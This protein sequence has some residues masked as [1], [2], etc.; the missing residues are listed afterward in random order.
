MSNDSFISKIHNKYIKRLLIDYKKRNVD[1]FNILKKLGS[2]DIKIKTDDCV[3][4]YDSNDDIYLKKLQAHTLVFL[5][6]EECFENDISI[7]DQESISEKIRKDL[8]QII[9]ESDEYITKIKFELKDENL[10]KKFSKVETDNFFTED[11]ES[12]EG[13]DVNDYLKTKI[14]SVEIPDFW[15]KD[16]LRVFISH[17]VKNYNVAKKLKDEFIKSSLSCFVAHKDIKPTTQWQKE[18]KKALNSMELMVALITEDFNE[19]YW[20]H[21]EVGFALGRDIPIIPIKLDQSDPKG[22]ISEIQAINLTETDI[23]PHYQ[24]F[25]N[26]LNLIQEKF[27]K[28]PFIKKKL[29]SAFLSAK[30]GSFA[31]AKEKFMEIISLDFND[32]EIEEIV[33]TIKGP[34]SKR[35]NQLTILLAPFPPAATITPEHLKQLPEEEKDKYKYYS[36]LLE[37]KVLSQHTQK[38]YF[39]KDCEIIDNQ[40]IPPKT[41]KVIKEQEFEDFSF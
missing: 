10:S 16:C 35:Y 9:S 38:R 36:E 20:T 18:I 11:S 41:Q 15:D 32:K 34:A 30:D 23:V 12:K 21:Q 13:I 1:L 24:S 17:S 2:D 31:W 26:L 4:D 14:K 33:K 6:P 37:D 25:L 39:I 28:H 5:L 29:L 7:S 8:N 27:P 19:S 3:E 22:F 40:A